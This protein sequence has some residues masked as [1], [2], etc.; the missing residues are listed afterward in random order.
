MARIDLCALILT[1]AL[2]LPLAACE[3][4]VGAPAPAPEPE[5]A[6][7]PSRPAQLD[8]PALDRLI[9]GIPKTALHLHIE[10]TFEPELAFAIARRN[11][12]E[13]G[14]E[15]FPYRT[16]D[17]LRAAYDF[18]DLGSFL[19]LY[20]ALSGVLLEERDFYDLASAYCKRIAA[21]NVQV[22][23]VFFDPQTHTSRGVPFTT[24][25]KGLQRAF[26]EAR[27]G[28][29]RVTLLMSFLRDAPVGQPEDMAGATPDR[30]FASMKEATAWAT[31][32]QGLAWNRTAPAADQLV[33]VALDSYE[34]PYPPQLFTEVY[35]RARD[36][37]LLTTAHAGEEGPPAYVWSALREL[38]VA[39]IDHGVRSAEDEALVAHLKRKHG[40]EHITAAYGEPHQIPLTVCP[41]SNY[42]LK[43]YPDPTEANLLELLDQGLLVTIN[44][45]DPSYFGG[46][47]SENYLAV[48]QWLDPT[49]DQLRALARNGF[50]AAWMTPEQ[51]Q[52]YLQMVDRSF[53]SLP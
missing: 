13:P 12:V 28:G 31:L 3:K 22:A 47:A 30:G 33:G 25:I 8:R 19:D 41:R 1:L 50:E 6:A 39:R 26:N 2:I 16:L 10:G 14:S 45:D 15:A 7:A 24:V 18:S 49:Y 51:K 5:A 34:K 27:Q 20:Y 4:G 40:D 46:Y 48:I 38:K 9:Q 11:G 44:S 21:Q 43:V 42:K 35:A 53:A 23:E 52:P 29:M 32:A 37:G 36:E 17:E